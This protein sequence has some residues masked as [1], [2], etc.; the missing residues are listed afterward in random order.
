MIT[1]SFGYAPTP[2]GARFTK[3]YDE[4]GNH[5]ITRDE[6]KGLEW[7]AHAFDGRNAAGFTNMLSR[8]GAGKVCRELTLGG[9]TDWR[10]P[11]I[12]EAMSIGLVD[13]CWPANEKWFWTCT[14]CKKEPENKAWAFEFGTTEKIPKRRYLNLHVRAVRGQMRT[15]AI[16]TPKAGAS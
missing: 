15:D 7:T 8:S 5:I 9:H 12:E 13:T 16:A 10:V 14:P 11:E 3:I 6:H 2:G 4:D 1:A